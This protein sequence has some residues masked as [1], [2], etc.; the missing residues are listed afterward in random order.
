[1][2]VGELLDG[3]RLDV[4]RRRA[5]TSVIFQTSEGQGESSPTGEDV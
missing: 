2:P 1:M 4:R 5:K 3:R